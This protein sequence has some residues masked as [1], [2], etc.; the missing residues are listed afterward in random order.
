MTKINH[1]GVRVTKLRDDIDGSVCDSHTAPF[2][3]MAAMNK[4]AHN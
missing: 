4:I 2:S 1:W 3:K